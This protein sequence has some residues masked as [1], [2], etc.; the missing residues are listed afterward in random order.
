[1]TSVVT[2]T[3]VPP[4]EGW[5]HR[6]KEPGALVYPLSDELCS[7]DSRRRWICDSCGAPMTSAYCSGPDRVCQGCWQAWQRAGFHLRLSEFLRDRS[8]VDRE[9][10]KLAA[11]GSIPGPATIS[12]GGVLARSSSWGGALGRLVPSGLARLFYFLRN[13]HE[14]RL[15]KYLA[16]SHGEWR[17]R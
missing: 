3:S 10:H 16:L 15:G 17:L 9:P 11:P 6:H 7:T 5:S 4:F 14:H 12:H 1:M 2:P 13:R 8:V